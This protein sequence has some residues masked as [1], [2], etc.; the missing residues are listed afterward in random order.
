M[1][2][3]PG[4][5]CVGFQA[6][7]SPKRAELSTAQKPALPL[8]QDQL[9]GDDRSI[10]WRRCWCSTG[11]GSAIILAHWPR[12]SHGGSDLRTWSDIASSFTVA[13]WLSLASVAAS[14]VTA[15]LA[16]YASRIEVRDSMDDFI[17]DIARQSL[18][19]G[20]A[21]AVGVLAGAL[22]VASVALNLWDKFR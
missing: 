11:G 13:E 3:G 18:W 5:R 12:A 17:G 16:L 14:M 21:A 8:R 10:S 15:G 6:N 7:R 9:F 19:N 22:L 2:D 1:G 4:R 20:R